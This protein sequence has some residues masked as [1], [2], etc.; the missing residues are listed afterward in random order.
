MRMSPTKKRA[1]RPPSKYGPEYMTDPQLTSRRLTLCTVGTN[2]IPTVHLSPTTSRKLGI[3]EPADP[4]I[5]TS[6]EQT[7]APANEPNAQLE[8][9]QEGTQ[10]LFSDTESEASEDEMVCI[11]ETQTEDTDVI[12]SL[13]H[14]CH[15]PETIRAD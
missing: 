11:P 9:A 8:S 6:R 10:A 5:N 2:S 3:S 1:I 4:E 14:S 15:I 13:S 7:S 12:P